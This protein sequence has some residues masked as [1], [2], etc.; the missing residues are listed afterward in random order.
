[1]PY[2]A[3]SF[4]MWVSYYDVAQELT[5][6]EQG[7]FYRAIMDYIFKGEDCEDDLRKSVKIC[8]KAIKANLK[9]SVANRRTNGSESGENRGE[10][11][12]PEN[13]LNLNL[14]SRLKIKS[15]GSGSG[16]GKPAPPSACPKCGGPL[17]KTAA[18]DQRGRTLYS[19]VKCHEE[20]W[21]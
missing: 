1:M 3:K 17:E 19:C 6:K 20:V 2:E 16:G 7:E 21:A 4:T 8:F 12:Q 13:A 15:A 10:V 9:R 11:P 14:N 5:P 18:H